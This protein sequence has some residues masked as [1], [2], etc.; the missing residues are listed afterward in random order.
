MTTQIHITDHWSH[1]CKP[2]NGV[3]IHDLS[4]THVHT[5]N[6]IVIFHS[7]LPQTLNQRTT[8]NRFK[9]LAE[10]CTFLSPCRGYPD[11]ALPPLLFEINFM[12]K[13]S[14]L[15]LIRQLGSRGPVSEC[16]NLRSPIKLSSL[17]VSSLGY[18]ATKR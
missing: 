11:G 6:L 3:R 7:D 1:E 10:Q 17:V 2:M 8:S 14:S 12:Q 18:L 5:H 15:S 9:T 16:R 4:F 13:I